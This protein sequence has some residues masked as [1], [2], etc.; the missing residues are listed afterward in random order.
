VLFC[1]VSRLEPPPSQLPGPPQVMSVVT[2][3][4]LRNL[5]RVL[6]KVGTSVVIHSDGSV[7]LGRIGHLVEQIGH[8]LV[9][10]A[11]SRCRQRFSVGRCERYPVTVGAVGLGFEC[12]EFF[13]MF[14]LPADRSKWRSCSERRL[15]TARFS[16]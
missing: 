4:D 11:S 5:R 9:R 7:A 1:A 12:L 2:R 16:C 10:G 15:G 3:K 6:V 13:P 8:I 14:S